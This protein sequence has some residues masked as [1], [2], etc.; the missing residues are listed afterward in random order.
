M[1]TRRSGLFSP[2]DGRITARAAAAAAAGRYGGGNQ[3][4]VCVCVMSP[5]SQTAGV[6][7]VTATM[8]VCMY[9]MAASQR[10]YVTVAFAF[11]S[12]YGISEKRW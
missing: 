12:M 4:S 8:Y 7:A 6:S 3:P 1:A 9:V 10:L 5:A 2:D 11:C